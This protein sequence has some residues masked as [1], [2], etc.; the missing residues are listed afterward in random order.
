MA[1]KAPKEKRSHRAAGLKARL[2]LNEEQVRRERCRKQGQSP[3]C[4]GNNCVMHSQ[5]GRL[6]RMGDLYT[7]LR[8][9][10]VKAS[11]EK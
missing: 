5:K 7:G 8:V 6:S 10:R 4:G 3:L 2:Q 11:K 9:L 1:G